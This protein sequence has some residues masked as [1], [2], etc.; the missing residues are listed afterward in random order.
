M[1]IFANLFP[2][3][4]QAALTMSY[5]DGCSYDKRLVEIFNQN[6]IRGTF[7]LNSVHL[8]DTDGSHVTA[9]EVRELY[10]GHE[11]SCHTFTHPFPSVTPDSVLIN[12]ILEDRRALEKAC[13][14][15]VRGM[16]YPYGDCSAHAITLFRACGMQYSRTVGATGGFGLPEDFMRW[17]PTCHHNGGDLNKLFDALL[18]NSARQPRHQVMYVWGHSYEFDRENNWGLMESFCAHAAGHTEVWYATNIEIYDYIC[19]SRSLMVGVDGYTVYNPSS[20]PVWVTADG[21]PT[22]LLPGENILA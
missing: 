17:N 11:V 13:G 18:A 7:H 15:T 16:S 1:R 8:S 3:G 5:D 6:G 10:K 2:E 4:K 12:E 21:Q 14:Y 9:E 20:I 22:K 19:A